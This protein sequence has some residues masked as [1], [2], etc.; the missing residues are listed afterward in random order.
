MYLGE[1]ARTTPDKPAVI[2]ARTGAAIT[3]RELDERSCRFAHYLRSLGLRAGDRIAVLMENNPCYFEVAWAGLR[4]GLYVTP[5]NRY[6]TPEEAA[7]V[8]TDCDARV[9]VS[10]SAMAATAG[11]LAD[12]IPSCPHRLMVDGTI[13]GWSSFETVMVSQPPTHPEGQ[14]LGEVM[15]YSSG[16]TGRPKGIQRPLVGGIGFAGWRGREPLSI[17]GFGPDTVYLSPA[18][19]YHA[20]P[21]VYST[22]QQFFGGT[23]V[24][25]DRFE[26]LEALAAI[27]RY[28]VTHSQWVP[29]M[30]VR[31]LRLSAEER[32]RYDLS[33]HRMAIHA[34]AP[35][36][37]DVK[38]G[39]IEWW[40]PILDEYY[41]GSE[42]NGSTR[43]TSAEW[44]RKPGSVGRARVGIVHICDDE[45]NEVATGEA[46]TVYFE[47]DIMP[48]AY[49]NDPEKTRGA[50]HP[51]H[52]KWST[53]GDVGYLDTEGFLFL[54]DR[55]AFMIISGGVNIYPQAIEDALIMHP[56]VGDVAVIGV[57]NPDMGEE[58][59]AIVEPAAGVAP[60]PELAAELIAFA[61]GKV[62]KYMVPRTVDF[63]AEMPRLPTGKL[64]KRVL[65]EKYWPQKV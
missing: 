13:S 23:V 21:L 63:I 57:P 36:P 48:F 40:G 32:G 17:Y 55:K 2:M 62:A 33:S 54:T 3:Y 51:R 53:L 20:A 4:I 64:Y 65:R 25:M 43:I 29:T 31:L 1:F 30:F 58:V 56:K 47:R 44:L 42:A 60:S 18:P 10:S 8:V 46:G 24:M 38:R 61:T 6:M 22:A 12:L 27:E 41:G 35:C 15:F 59:K 39:M 45:G 19:L 16:T 7:Y 5:V 34:A 37:I 11:P 9:I 50:Y 14:T 52:P 49:L 28:K 26:P